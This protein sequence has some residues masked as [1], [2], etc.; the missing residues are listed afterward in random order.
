MRTIIVHYHIFKNA[1]SS[2]DKMLEMSF[3]DR[4]ATFEGPT[5]TSLLSPRDLCLFARDHPSLCAVSSR[6]L[7]PPAPPELNV[8]SIVLVRHPLDRA[9]SVYS[10][11]RRNGGVMPSEQAARRSSFAGFVRWCLDYKSLGGMVIADYQVIHLSEASLRNGHIYN[12]VATESDLRQA[13]TYLSND[14][15]FGPV[16]Q[17]D[18]VMGTLAG[19]RRAG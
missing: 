19:S 8:L 5:A 3:G 4:W 14:A 13:M 18:A 6:L 10:Q 11:L 2:V 17:L 9:Y 12:A 7:R 16:E 15:I 1:G